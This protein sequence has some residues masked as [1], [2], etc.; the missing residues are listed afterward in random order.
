MIEPN[1]V[2]GATTTTPVGDAGCG[3]SVEGFAR[4]ITGGGGRRRFRA[5]RNPLLSDLGRSRL[6][7]GRRGPIGGLNALKTVP[8]A[9]E[10]CG[11]RGRL[12]ILSTFRRAGGRD[13][14]RG[15]GNGSSASFQIRHE[16][17]NVRSGAS[18]C[19]SLVVVIG[20]RCCGSGGSFGQNAGGEC[21]PHCRL[22]PAPP[23]PLVRRKASLE[24]LRN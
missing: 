5:L 22:M 9:G 19:D 11:R 20:V 3:F 18:R 13:G 2:S 1:I 10:G 24:D 21:S 17:L 14:I 6:G 4:V 23:A 7:F 12:V 16:I 8:A 15:G